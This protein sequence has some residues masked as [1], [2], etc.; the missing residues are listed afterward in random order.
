MAAV[1]EL[2]KLHLASGV[3]MQ[4]GLL[5]P[6]MAAPV[7]STNAENQG[8]QLADQRIGEALVSAASLMRL[9]CYAFMLTRNT[10]RQAYHILL[11]RPR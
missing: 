7:V 1:A 9:R 4:A 3:C 8:A 11:V 5:D 6:R 10:E 2:F